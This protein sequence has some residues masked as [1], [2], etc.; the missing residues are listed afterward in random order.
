MSFRIQSAYTIIELLVVMAI[1]SLLYSMIIVMP[2]E[3]A[4]AK[5]LAS[6]QELKATLA[7]ARSLAMKTGKNH[8]VAFQI[9]NSADG[10]VMKNFSYQNNM[11]G[12]ADPGGHWYAIIGPDGSTGSTSRWTTP[13]WNKWWGSNNTHM[14]NTMNDMESAMKAAQIGK[15]HYLQEGVRFLALNDL[16][17][18]NAS[19]GGNKEASFPRP[20]YGYYDSGRLYAWGG[21]DPDTDLNK[22]A[23][24]PNSGFCYKGD[25]LGNFAYDSELDTII[26]SGPIFGRID[27]FYQRRDSSQA[28]DADTAAK[29]TS[30]TGKPRA[31]LNAYWIDCMILFEAEGRAIWVWN[32]ARTYM[33]ESTT[34]DGYGAADTN[35]WQA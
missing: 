8:A 33:F 26:N 7:K 6:A 12:D 15:K 34:W 18:G 5:L 24:N 14:H 1:I 30:R 21:Y 29:S 32:K 20:W 35:P 23:T 13:M 3:S 10:A 11:D 4:E 28:S 27:D 9:E 16:D 25:D 19:Y 17:N 2:E 31:L 22:H